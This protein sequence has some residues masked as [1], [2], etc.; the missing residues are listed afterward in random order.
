VFD[1]LTVVGAIKSESRGSHRVRTASGSDRI[2]HSPLKQ[3]TAAIALDTFQDTSMIRSLPLAVLT[4]FVV[5]L[6]SN[7]TQF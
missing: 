7:C 4:R 1:G 3:I 5:I 6:A 2:E